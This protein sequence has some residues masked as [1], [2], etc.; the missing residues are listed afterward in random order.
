MSELIVEVLIILLLIVAN[1]VF[2]MSEIAVVS[3]RKARLEQLANEGDPRAR[4]ALE[5]ANAPSRFLSTVQVGI[6]LIG[7]LAGA[8]GGVTI[9]RK[10]A[11]G[12]GTLPG[13]APYSQV[14]GIAIVVVALTYLSLIV[15]ELV[16]K[17]LALNDPE[18]VASLVAGPMRTLSVMASPIVR[19]LSAST[20]AALRVLRARPSAGPPV[21]EEEIEVLIAQGTE[22]GVFLEA[23]EDIVKSVF[24][25]SDRKVSSLMTPR[26]D[27]V[28]LDVGDPPEAVRRKI[29]ESAHSRF[30]VGQGG[31]DNVVGVVR[32][33]DLLARCLAGQPV[34]VKASLQHP[35]FVHESLS[36]FQLLEV[37][38][39][40]R[41][42]IALVVDEFGGIQ[43][44]VT[45]K[46]IS[47]AILGDVPSVEEMREPEVLRREDGS[48]LMDGAL[49][50]DEFQE[51]VRC[52]KLPDEEKGYYQTLGGFV[53]THLGR[54]PSAGDRFDWDALRFEVMDM[55]GRR[56]DKVLVTPLAQPP[57]DPAAASR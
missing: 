44:M 41:A 54:I 48:W 38:K 42:H 57:P 16:P 39:T 56:V 29:V 12:L 18:R 2:A 24:R 15:G 13:L 40:S 51:V 7:I 45:L 50:M 6:T 35:L 3:A 26:P 5:L 28:W 36:A 8:F 53:M 31:L 32:A 37:L 4:A 11:E 21:T 33:K 19:L 10:L 47:E 25:L 1:G 27:I 46:D 34:D 17:R 55:D 49:P 30:P 43:G 9:A 22:A 14:L 52:G 20:D 23:E